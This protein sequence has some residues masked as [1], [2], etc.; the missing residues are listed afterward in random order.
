MAGDV[1]LVA[2]VLNNL[3]YSVLGSLPPVLMISYAAI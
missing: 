1:W 3:L 2:W